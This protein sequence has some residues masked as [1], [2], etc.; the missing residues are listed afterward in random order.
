MGAIDV[1]EGGEAL[2][3]GVR[4]IKPLGV[5]VDQYASVLGVQELFAVVISL[6]LIRMTPANNPVG[7]GI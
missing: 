7:V 5:D 4:I 6:F 3:D 2:L 1:R